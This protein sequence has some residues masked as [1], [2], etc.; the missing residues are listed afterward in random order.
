MNHTK[1]YL[2]ASHETLG[3][4]YFSHLN[5]WKSDREAVSDANNRTTKKHAKQLL[6]VLKPLFYYQFNNTWNLDILSEFE[7]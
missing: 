5:G 4:L 3:T 2:I 7:F 1:Y 6:K